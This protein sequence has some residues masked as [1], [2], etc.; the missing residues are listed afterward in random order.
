[1]APSDAY[2]PRE[3]NTSVLPNVGA[4]TLPIDKMLVNRLPR[5]CFLILVFANLISIP[6]FNFRFLFNLF[7][8]F[9]AT[10][11]VSLQE[12]ALPA[13]LRAIVSL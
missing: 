9:D 10:Y 8:I 4:K 7:T 1:M 12:S 3:A 11:N 13:S 6:L 2:P 5:T